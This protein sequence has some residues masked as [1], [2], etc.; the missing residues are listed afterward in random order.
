ML[1]QH[2]AVAAKDARAERLLEADA[3]GDLRRGAQKAV[4]MD[5][6]LAAVASSHGTMWPGTLV[7]NETVPGAC[8][9]GTRS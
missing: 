7:A 2:E 3:D 5:H 1:L 9:P 6:V 8:R 4:A